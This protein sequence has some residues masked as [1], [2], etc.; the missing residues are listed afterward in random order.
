MKKWFSRRLWYCARSVES[1]HGAC[2]VAIG[3]LVVIAVDVDA[4]VALARRHSLARRRVP[5]LAQ[6]LCSSQQWFSRQVMS[7]RQH[8]SSS[9]HCKHVNVVASTSST[10]QTTTKVQPRE[11]A[12][13]LGWHIPCSAHSIPDSWTCKPRTRCGQERQRN[14]CS[15]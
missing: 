5:V 10:L 8:S 3:V 12:E 7:S 4:A 14:Q 6:A 2:S 15:R 1:G 9:Q 11:A 13:S